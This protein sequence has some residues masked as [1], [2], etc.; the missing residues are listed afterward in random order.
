MK[1]LLLLLA[2]AASFSGTA[3]AQATT[4][5]SVVQRAM[6]PV[7]YTHDRDLARWALDI[8]LK[9]GTLHQD[10]TYNASNA[11]YLNAIGGGVTRVGN[12]HLTD[13]VTYGVDG[14]LG[15]FFG[16]NRHWGIG[17]GF[18]YLAQR[19]DAK[20]DQFH[21]EYQAT[22]AQG[23]VFR[24][25]VT[26]RDLR[27]RVE[28]TNLNIPVML[29]YKA[30]F[31]RVL[32]FTADAGILYNLQMR[33][34]TQ[35]NAKFD[36]GA[37]YQYSATTDGL[38]TSYD[39]SPVPNVNDVII[40]RDFYLAHNPGGNVNTYFQE[41]SA[42]GRTI[43]LDRMPTNRASE[44]SYKKGSVGFMIQPGL[45]FYLS[46]N[47]ALNLNVYYM[48]QAFEATPKANYRLTGNVG[49]YSSMLNTVSKSE[50][51]SIGGNFGVRFLFGKARDSDKDGIPDKKDKC[52]YV[53]GL[54]Q[55]LG[56][57]DTDKDGIPDDQ[58]SCAKIAGL[59]QFHGCP[60]SDN[61]GIPDKTDECPYQAGPARFHGCPDR[62]GDGIPDKEDICPDKAGTA[63]YHG[64][65][66]TDGDGIPDNEDQCPEV[67]GTADN[68]GCPPPPPPAETT[69]LETPI[70]FEVNR[71]VVAEVSIPVLETAIKKLNEDPN[72]VI[73]IDG[74]TDI[75]GTKAYNKK[76]SMRRALAVKKKLVGMGADP[77]RIKVVGH[78]PKYPAASNKTP[79]GRQQNRRAVM[80]L[81]V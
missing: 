28:I 15:F 20:L 34:E 60:D 14:Q 72:G 16:R 63:Q 62:D 21:A 10:I 27:E 26:G 25:V 45:S 13:G 59:V 80:K 40:T 67:A 46:D 12:L 56:C 58:D 17:A 61:D 33:N 54:P 57:P 9:L 3:L 49:E 6:W 7:K 64:C 19:T 37:I 18:M 35:T 8:N 47:V 23:N 71:T 50:N 76:L 38:P 79:E 52:P 70:L 55:F 1:K 5:D 77:K 41:Q 51:H 11:A 24:Q 32:G 53:M 74:Y 36:Y 66:D 30:R 2:A 68:H 69:P 73:V 44:V 4:R 39:A 75:T 29:K 31:S 78:G 22:D 43:A 65:P 48:Y 42:A 81:K